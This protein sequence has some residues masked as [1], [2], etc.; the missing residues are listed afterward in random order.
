[1]FSKQGYHFN[2]IF[3]DSAN[4][5]EVVGAKLQAN[6]Y[7]ED[8]LC[9]SSGKENFNESYL[10]QLYF[11]NKLI[12]AHHLTE[13]VVDDGANPS[14]NLT[15][16]SE[17]AAEVPFI[18]KKNVE[19]EE[20]VNTS[21]SSCSYENIEDEH[22]DFEHLS[23]EDGSVESHETVEKEVITDATPEPEPTAPIHSSNEMFIL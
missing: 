12:N 13:T 1:M 3:L 8:E 4:D 15:K 10:S 22:E 11:N 14:G 6:L 20:T 23:M 17:D 16:S 19:T 7:L 9:T 21:S 18:E 2:F 5:G